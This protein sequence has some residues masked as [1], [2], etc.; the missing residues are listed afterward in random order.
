MIPIAIDGL[1][2]EGFRRSIELMLRRGD[3]DRAGERLRALLAPYVGVGKLL[4]PQFLRVLPGDLSI[5]G[6]DRLGE[7]VA[8][9]DRP[10]HPVTA[11]SICFAHP[12]E[13][14]PAAASARPCFETTY[15]SDN[16]FT[17][18]QSTRDDLLDGYS[19]FGCDWAG[20]GE[21]SDRAFALAGIDDLH[22]A[23]GRLEARL[24]ASEEPDPDEIRAG[25]LGACY[26]AV[27]LFQ[28]LRDTNARA[29]LPRPLCIM[30]G[31][32]DVYPYFD[33]PVTGIEDPEAGR[34]GTL[35]QAG[36]GAERAGA[37]DKSQYASLLMSRIPRAKKRA[38]L[39]LDESIDETEV[40]VARLRGLVHED[41]KPAA[42]EADIEPAIAAGAPVP[43]PGEPDGA[44]DPA[45]AATDPLAE[46]RSLLKTKPRPSAP[47]DGWNGGAGAKPGFDLIDFDEPAGRE[48]T[49][50]RFKL[51][52]T[53]FSETLRA[54]VAPVEE[55]APAL[56]P[57]LPPALTPAPPPAPAP[58]WPL[59]RQTIRR[60]ISRRSSRHG[61]RRWRR[62]SPRTATPRW[63]RKQK[64]P[65][66]SRRRLGQ[67]L[68]NARTRS[69]TPSGRAA[70]S[71]GRPGWAS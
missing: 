7:C 61:G 44:S 26:L 20:D 16:A 40:R 34:D 30:A 69:A 58:L 35:E 19:T 47:G 4:P 18:S 37:G 2:E 57:A 13:N 50:V 38:V 68:P 71:P 43:A 51:D 48:Q 24:L 39:V 45:T 63:N 56:A 23:L 14:A 32:T 55:P 25:S 10:D 12:P 15:Y 22:N 3:F 52:T 59:R 21:A 60:S 67:L 29:G 6:W 8:R 42:V 64:R 36:P 11:L 46:L 17:F 62:P 70:T 54:S 49:F 28:T 65:T 41:A 5:A 31:N 66:S 1:D 33:A 9:Y 27:L 53:I